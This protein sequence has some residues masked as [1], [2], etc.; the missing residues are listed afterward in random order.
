MSLTKDQRFTERLHGQVHFE[1]F[2]ILNKTEYTPAVNGNP[3]GRSNPLVGS[4]RATPD[5]QISNPEVDS[6]AACS[7]QLGW[8]LAF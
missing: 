3:A 5:V 4:S 2:N 6:G 8:K 7:I 1:V